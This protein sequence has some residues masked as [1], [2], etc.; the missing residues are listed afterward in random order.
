MEATV[1]EHSALAVVE[2]YFDALGRGDVEAAM[3]ALDPD[4]V[5]HQPGHNRFS[6]IHQG[7]Q[8]VA[9]MVGG[10]VAVSGGTFT[11]S[12]AGRPMVNGE[13]VAVPVRFGGR[14]QGAAMDMAG[15]D[16]LT[17]RD[18]SIVRVDLFSEDGPAEDR[19]WGI[20]RPVAG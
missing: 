8:A 20:D 2:G 9:A 12:V 19:F 6:G 17:V 18:G 13:R 1:G 3:G 11:L 14:R 10:M 16:L 5:W 4:V 15:I 7:P